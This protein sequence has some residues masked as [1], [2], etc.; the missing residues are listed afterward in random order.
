M[1]ADKKEQQEI[2]NLIGTDTFPDA[3]FLF[4]MLL[5]SLDEQSKETLQ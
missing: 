5:Q 3:P 1:S 2:L 4:E